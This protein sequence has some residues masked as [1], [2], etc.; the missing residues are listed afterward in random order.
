MFLAGPTSPTAP[1]PGTRGHTSSPWLDRPARAAHWLGRELGRPRVRLGVLGGVSVL[2]G[3][4]F[5][6]SSVWTLPLVIA[7]AVMLVVAWVGSRLD[8]R[9]AI[10]WGEAGT[11]LE[12]RAQIKAPEPAVPGVALARVDEV[13]PEPS[14]AEVVDGEAHTVEIEVA[15]LEALIA[16]VEAR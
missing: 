1:S 15:E 2:L 8:G 4:V 5:V 6:T 3:M 13:E 10:E 14:D 9:L 7:G 11:R 16:A 12:F